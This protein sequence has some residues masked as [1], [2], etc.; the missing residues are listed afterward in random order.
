MKISNPKLN[1][2]PILSRIYCKQNNDNLYIT[3]SIN[4][5][6]ENE[7]FCSDKNNN[8]L[9]MISSSFKSKIKDIISI[10]L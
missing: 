3:A 10:S 7:L 5:N 1:S 4:Q 2:I 8:P 6:N 9:K